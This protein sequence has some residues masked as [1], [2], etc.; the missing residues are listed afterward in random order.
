[1]LKVKLVAYTPCPERLIASAAR[2]CYSDEGYD[3]ILDEMSDEKVAGLVRMLTE[4]GHESPIE[5]ASFTFDID[6]VSRSLMAQLTRHRIASYSIRSQRYVH[7]ND[8]EYITPPEI[9]ADPE[10]KKTFDTAMADAMAHYKSISDIL[11]KRHYG[12]LIFEGQSEK[13]AAAAA[14]KQANEDARFVLPNAIVTRIMMTMNA[15][16]LLNLF[17]LRCCGRAQWEIRGLAWAMLYEV[18]RV[19]PEIFSKAGPPCLCGPCSQ[20]KMSC[21]R[22]EEFRRRSEEITKR[23]NQER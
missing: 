12:R 15:R 8:M 5:H 19:A 23:L 21:G 14:E 17:Q 13:A 4:M 11:Y 7:Y 2:V 22:A 16:S 6:G 3:E 20:G 1:M 18:R 9:A 10:A